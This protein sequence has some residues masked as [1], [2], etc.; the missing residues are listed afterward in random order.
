[1]GL[2]SRKI[3]E[4]R[5]QGRRG[6][7]L[8]EWLLWESRRRKKRVLQ[9]QYGTKLATTRGCLPQSWCVKSRVVTTLFFAIVQSSGSIQNNRSNWDWGFALVPEWLRFE[10]F[11]FGKLSS[12]IRRPTVCKMSCDGL[13]NSVLGD[14]VN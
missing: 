1:L 2:D 7:E 13:F 9:A 14:R 12:L 3:R 4:T 10:E 5:V 6:T 8:M 11:G